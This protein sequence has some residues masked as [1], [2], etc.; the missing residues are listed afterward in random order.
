MSTERLEIRANEPLRSWYHLSPF[1]WKTGDGYAMLLRAVPRRDDD[2]SKKISSIF[3]GTS[4]DG[5]AFDMDD[6]PVIAPGQ[7]SEDRDGCEDPTLVIDDDLYAVFYT[8]WNE[9]RKTASL[10][11][12][13][14]PSP[15]ALSKRGVALQS[16][17]ARA[18]PKEATIVRGRDGWTM[19]YEFSSAGASRIG[20]ARTNALF[21][22][23][24]ADAEPFVA[25]PSSWDSWHLSTGP[26]VA[27]G[28]LPLMFYNGATRD[29][30]W[31]IGWVRFDDAYHGVV[32]RC[33]EPLIVP[34][35][36]T[37]NATDIA[38]AASAVSSDD[39]IA[40]YYSV[41]DKLLLRATLRARTGN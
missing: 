14:G 13:S 17:D 16:T 6:E 21:G 34:E 27:C 8:G 4:R 7:T 37:G 22:P 35:H 40:L 15:R 18:N 41:S 11:I 2:P 25:R 24:V 3:F 29:A 36:V 5:L 33:D 10:L 28:G 1:V 38:F 30:H 23:W 31:R 39:A 19:L 9:Q 20:T 32:D 12:A 26:I